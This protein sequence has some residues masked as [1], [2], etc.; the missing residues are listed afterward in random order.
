MN[1]HLQN[2]LHMQVIE[3]LPFTC[4]L[5]PLPDTKFS[6]VTFIVSLLKTQQFTIPSLPTKKQEPMTYYAH[7]R[8]IV[9]TVH[10]Y[11]QNF[12]RYILGHTLWVFN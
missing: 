10:S 4:I 8:N 7:L 6:V 9:H 2:K 3:Y 1:I 12:N 5:F 11:V